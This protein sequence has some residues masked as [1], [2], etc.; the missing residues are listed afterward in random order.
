MSEGEWALIG[1]LVGALTTGLLNLVF[2]ARQFKHNIEMHQ[3]EN[4]SCENV[5][6]LLIEKLNHRE[7]TDR[8]FEALKNNIGGFKDDEIRLLLHEIDAVQ[9]QSKK[10]EEYWYLRSRANER[11]KA[12]T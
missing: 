5:K 8:S 7:Y 2:Q 6:A 11:T 4:Q 12:G 9:V 1:V 10:G 3:L